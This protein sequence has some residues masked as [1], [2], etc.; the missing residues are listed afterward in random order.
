MSAL[1]GTSRKCFIC[2]IESDNL[3]IGSRN[4]GGICNTCI[5]PFRAGL[6]RGN[7][8]AYKDMIDEE[9]NIIGYASN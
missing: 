5:K 2:K 7:I 1:Q 9:G 3:W 8:E 4:S 6:R